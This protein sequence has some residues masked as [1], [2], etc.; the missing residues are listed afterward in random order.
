MFVQSHCKHS[1]FNIQREQRNTEEKQ[2]KIVRELQ[3]GYKRPGSQK[4]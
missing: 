1:R 3:E 2:K 4:P